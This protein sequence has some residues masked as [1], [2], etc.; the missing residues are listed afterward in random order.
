[1]ALPPQW[2]AVTARVGLM[3]TAPHTWLPPLR[4]DACHGWLAMFAFDPPST[5]PP[6]CGRALSAAETATPETDDEWNIKLAK[7]RI[8]LKIWA[9]FNVHLIAL[10]ELEN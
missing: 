7:M 1:M 8:F 9:S 6:R 3:S 5:P 10:C 2:A 4:R